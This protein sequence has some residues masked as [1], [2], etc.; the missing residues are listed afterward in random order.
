MSTPTLKACALI[1][2]ALKYL[3]GLDDVSEYCQKRKE[4]FSI[5]RW[6]KLSRQRAFLACKYSPMFH[7]MFNEEL[8]DGDVHMT[9]SAWYE[10]TQIVRKCRNQTRNHNEAPKGLH[11]GTKEACQHLTRDLYIQD[12]Q[13]QFEAKE[14]EIK[15]VDVR[16]SRTPLL[17]FSQKHV[18]G[19]RGQMDT[20]EIESIRELLNMQNAVLGLKFADDEAVPVDLQPPMVMLNQEFY[21]KT[22]LE[23]KHQ[24]CENVIFCNQK[25]D[26]RN[27]R[28]EN[29]APLYWR[30]RVNFNKRR[31]FMYCNDAEWHSLKANQLLL[32]ML[33]ENFGWILRYFGALFGVRPTEM[34]YEL[35]ILE[36][37]LESRDRE[38]FGK[39]VLMPDAAGLRANYG[40]TK[41]ID[42]LSMMS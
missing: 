19:N 41:K 10:H 12:F 9:P 14:S 35:L 42:K 1:L 25:I 11:N 29:P 26:N 36:E 6:M 30:C 16:K 8:F 5:L 23:E 24:E 34:Y 39:F 33:P 3:F 40:T 21:R 20:S 37:F 38:Y 7:D 31:A 13:D 27:E 17:D 32:S 15:R 2:M 4:S 28:L 22:V 18:K